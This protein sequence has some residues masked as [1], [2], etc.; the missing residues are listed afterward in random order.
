MGL[1]EG[2]N[3]SSLDGIPILDVFLALGGFLA[4]GSFKKVTGFPRFLRLLAF[5]GF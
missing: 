5:V 2:A 3:G 4:F 1:E